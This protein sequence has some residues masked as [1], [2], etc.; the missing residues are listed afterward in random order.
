VGELTEVQ[1]TDMPKRN[2]NFRCE[3]CRAPATHVV[4]GHS[5]CDGCANRRLAAAT[6]W[7]ELPTP[8]PPETVVGADSRAHRI[9]YRLLRGPCGVEALAE[10][11]GVPTGEGYEVSVLGP[12]DAD[13]VRLVEA[14]REQ[15]HQE[16]AQVYLEES[17]H[18]PGWQISGHELAGRLEEDP[19][20][21][22]TGPPRMVIDGRSLSW[23]QVGDL[24][25][26]YVGCGF[27]LTFE[28]LEAPDWFPTQHQV[29]LD[30]DA[31]IAVFSVPQGAPPG[32]RVINSGHY[33]G[34][35]R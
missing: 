30:E 28:G 18:A 31:P 11:S 7:P 21:D 17:P 25:S 10:E 20:D 35:P 22:W 3:D 5:L 19:A 34:A 2:P 14:L 4:D 32:T 23:D 33:R 13:P 29:G 15:V 12:P 9:V 16:L 26:P 8:P 27:H 1:E 24:L 6:G